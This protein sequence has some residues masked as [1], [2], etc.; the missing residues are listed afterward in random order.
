MKF[1]HLILSIYII[2]LS[3]LPCT[4]VE[5]NIGNKRAL[6]TTHEKATSGHQDDICSPFCIC[7]CC[8]SFGFYKTADY[9]VSATIKINR[10]SSKTEYSSVFLSNFYAS[11][12]QPP[13]IC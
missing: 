2:A 11:I 6:I 1:I 10:E 13:K 8:H 7:N 3:C 9:L 4:D 5:G 12:W